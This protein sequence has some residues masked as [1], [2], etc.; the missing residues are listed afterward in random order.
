MEGP[1]SYVELWNCFQDTGETKTAE[2]LD[3]E[4]TSH[5]SIAKVREII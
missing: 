4:P 5:V 3:L 2:P 1:R